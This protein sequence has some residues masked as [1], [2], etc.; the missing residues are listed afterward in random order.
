MPSVFFIMEETISVHHQ[1]FLI[2][3][4]NLMVLADYIIIRF[5]RQFKIF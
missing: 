3:I 4:R 2:Q 1:T 5:S